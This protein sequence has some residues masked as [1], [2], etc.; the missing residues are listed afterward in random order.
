MLTPEKL[1]KFAQSFRRAEE[2]LKHSEYVDTF[3]VP[4]LNELR[5]AA[6]HLLD[7]LQENEGSQATEH[8]SKA[9]RHTQRAYY[10]AR[11]AHVISTLDAIQLI[12][13]EYQGNLD[14]V[15]NR[16]PEYVEG[17]VCANK[18]RELIAKCNNSYESRE[19]FYETLDAFLPTLESFLSK[20]K[21]TKHIIDAEV[22]KYK[23]KV[24]WQRIAGIA[25]VFAVIAGFTSFMF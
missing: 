10:D 25:G 23:Q 9:I 8:I 14:I 12:Q 2:A 21:A 7:A 24:F 11:E 1:S 4:S 13:T 18:A 3:D 6:K 20:L 19:D 15:A 16:V 22:K 5:Y 17:T